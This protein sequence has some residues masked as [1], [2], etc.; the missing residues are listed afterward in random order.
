MGG[1]TLIE[2][3]V[4]IVITAI[5]AAMVSVFIAGPVSGY[6]E[7]ARRSEL[8]DVAD[9][10]LRRMSREVRQSLPNSIRITAGNP[11]YLEFIPTI[12]GGSYRDEQDGSTAGI[13]L[14]FSNPLDCTILANVSSCRFDVIGTMPANPPIT[15]GD[16]IVVLN[17]GEV[18]GISQAPSDAYASGDLCT[19]CNRAKVR[20]GVDAAGNT[21]IT[22]LSNTVTLTPSPAAGSPNVFTTQGVGKSDSDATNRFHVVSQNAR[23]VMYECPTIAPGGNLVRYE[24]YGFY[25][26]KADAVTNRAGGGATS[27]I[28]AGNVFCEMSYSAN[29]SQQHTGLLSI[30][31][32]LRRSDGGDAEIVT[33][34]RQVHLDNSP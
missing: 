14:N 9:L 31:L 6:V 3:I 8:M 11:M 16:Y 21:G 7:S 25:T 19:N 23:T 34:M 18:S 12:G 33:L 29:A 2:A 28:L 10:V 24:N 22:A 32:T 1:F 20:T 26:A 17:F 30:K 4:A 13:P 27:S 15:N 5:L